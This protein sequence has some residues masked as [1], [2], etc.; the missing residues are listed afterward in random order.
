[1][2]ILD[3]LYSLGVF[4]KDSVLWISGLLRA[5]ASP[6]FVVIFLV[7]M[8]VVLT[9]LLARF[10]RRFCAVAKEAR[11]KLEGD[12]EISGEQVAALSADFIEWRNDGNADREAAVEQIFVQTED[13]LSARVEAIRE[14]H[15]VEEQ[16]NDRT[17]RLG[18]TKPVTVHMPMAIH[19]D[20]VTAS[21]DCLLHDLM[22]GKR[23][24]AEAALW[25][26]E[27]VPENIGALPGGGFALR[28]RA[29]SPPLELRRVPPLTALDGEMMALW[30]GYALDG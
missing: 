13:C 9:I 8:L 23:R 28:G 4:V 3:T 29:G 26:A 1:M 21:F 18:Q 19:P 2:R 25:P 6:G 22:R 20:Y 7:S 15:A 30:P 10:V 5:D 16:C 17:H 11:R 24:L 14:D 27:D 12:E